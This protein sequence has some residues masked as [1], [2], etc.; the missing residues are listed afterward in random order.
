LRLRLRNAVTWAG[1]GWLATRTRKHTYI[2]VRAHV[3]KIARK[4]CEEF[5]FFCAC[6]PTRLLEILI[7]A[8]QVTAFVHSNLSLDGWI[9]F[10]I[11]N[12]NFTNRCCCNFTAKINLCF[13]SPKRASIFLHM[14]KDKTLTQ[15][16]IIR[17]KLYKKFEL[18]W[19]QIAFNK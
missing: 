4:F 12:S 13:L 17:K 5:L 1:Q 11:F 7:C 3:K 9:F 16:L 19:A 15:K 8:P 6:R 10:L 18:N 14:Y 2:R